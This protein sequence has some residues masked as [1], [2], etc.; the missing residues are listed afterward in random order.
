MVSS[1]AALR[2]YLNSN[3]TQSQTL[4]FSRV[5]SEAVFYQDSNITQGLLSLFTQFQAVVNQG[6][7]NNDGLWALGAPARFA[8]YS[9]A[10]SFGSNPSL[11]FDWLYRRYLA[12]STPLSERSTCLRALSSTKDETLREKVLNATLAVMSTSGCTCVLPARV[13]GATWY[14]CIPNTTAPGKYWCFTTTGCGSQHPEGYW[15]DTCSSPSKFAILAIDVF[16]FV[17]S[18][19]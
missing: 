1:Q 16:F 6:L 12:S 2:S 14:G 17:R 19:M 8:T 4:M 11:A 15:R 5:L 10:V 9:A 18:Q 7:E 13:D 3:L